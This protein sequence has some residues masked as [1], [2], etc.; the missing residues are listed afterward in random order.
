MAFERAERHVP[1]LVTSASGLRPISFDVFETLLVRTVSPPAAVFEIVGTIA[2]ERGLIDI[3]GHIFGKAREFAERRANTSG[4]DHVTLDDIYSELAFSLGLSRQQEDGAKALELEVERDLLQPVPSI[5]GLF[6]QARR[7]SHRIIF[8]SD[9]HLPAE[10]IEEQLRLHGFWQDGD[11]LYV[12]HTHGCSK[13]NGSLFKTLSAIERIDLRSLT[14]YGNNR[15]ADVEGATKVGARGQ[16]IADGNP[17]RYEAVLQRHREGTGNLTAIYAGASRLARMSAAGQTEG[18]RALADVAAGVIAPM[19]TSYLLWALARAKALGLKRLY[20]IARDAE[21]LMQM[22]KPLLDKLGYDV[23]LRYLYASRMVWNRTVNPEQSPE[24]WNSLVWQS[25]EGVT[26]RDLLRRTGVDQGKLN[27][28]LKLDADPAWDSTA[29]RDVLMSA[30]RSP[31]MINAMQDASAE[32]RRVLE[33]YLEQEGLFDGEPHGFVDLGWKGTQHEVLIDLQN[34]RAVAPAAGLFFGLEE[35]ACRWGE[36]REAYYFDSRQRQDRSGEDGRKSWRRG[37]PRTHSQFALFE[38]FCAGSEGTLV[39]YTEHDGRICPVLGEGRQAE[40]E[41]W[42]LQIVRRTLLAF[43]TSLKPALG[44]R[45]AAFDARQAIHDAVELF[46]LSPTRSEAEAW[47]SFPWEI[48][49]GDRLRSVDFAPAQTTGKL[50]KARVDSAV[51][52]VRAAEPTQWPEGSQG[53]SGRAANL[54][55]SPRQSIRRVSKF[56]G[57]VKR[58]LRSAG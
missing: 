16:F 9:M 50:L 10:F 57:R 22:T 14:H 43:V 13:R 45:S 48:G 46:R 56:A 55:H 53:R 18:E 11:G 28:A 26:N 4:G 5:I 41:R 51:A 32:N 21:V 36:L 52:K 19:L 8:V 27:D 34:A 3:P 15:P 38:M 40:V 7:S 1:D 49:Q 44:L 37:V 17:N 25:K 58:R 42:G 35:S 47:G 30:L 2:A 12:S 20:F 54:M 33:R 39:G 29:S 6:H 24:V 31:H 23:E